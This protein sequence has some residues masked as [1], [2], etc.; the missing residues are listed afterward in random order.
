[1]MGDQEEPAAKCAILYRR[2]AHGIA[3]VS[4]AA[5]A[6]SEA[7]SR[8]NAVAARMRELCQE[9]ERLLETCAEETISES[10]PFWGKLNAVQ[11][12]CSR[13]EGILRGCDVALMR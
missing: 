4:N 1:M 6:T 9:V 12:E 10:S 8:L 11:R 5:G 3:D 2:L 13:L 7:V